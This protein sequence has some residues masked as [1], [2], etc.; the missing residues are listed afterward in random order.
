[1]KI[2]RLGRSGL[3]VSELAL[4]TWR[5]GRD[6]GESESFSQLDLFSDQGGNF[7]DTADVYGNGLAEEIVG[8]WLTSR[9]GRDQLVIGTKVWGRTGD[10]PNALGLSRKHILTAIDESL[11]RLQTDYVDLYYVHAWDPGVQLEESLSTLDGLVRAGKVRHV[12]ASNWLG[13]QLVHASGLARLNGWE[14]F[15]CVQNE[16]NLLSRMCDLEVLPAC[17]ETGLVLTPWSPLGGGWLTGKYRRDSPAPTAGT[18][19]ADWLE[20][21]QPDSWEHRANERTWAVIDA[22]LAVAEARGV[23]P[24][25]VAL[26]WLRAKPDVVAPTIGARTIEQLKSN[27]RSLGWELEP[28][29]IARLDEVSEIPPDSL[30][31]FVDEMERRQGRD[32]PETS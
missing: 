9:G 10:G 4:G 19:V 5:F 2:V 13:W 24:E 18:R 7:I 28:E 25:Q 22:V 6:T 31:R 12:G 26:N 23:G 11:R 3:R 32:A 17:R 1:M 8:R 27:L 20:P 29:E 15:V 30:Y 21:W 14:Q 16:Y